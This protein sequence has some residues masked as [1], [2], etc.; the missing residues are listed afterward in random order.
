MTSPEAH[1]ATRP[2]RILPGALTAVALVFLVVSLL[3]PTWLYSPVNPAVP[4]PEMHL[5]FDDLKTATAES[6]SGVQRVYFAWLGWALVVLTVLSAVAATRIRARVTAMIGL[7]IA[8]VT[9]VI[10][11]FAVKG[12]LSWSAFFSNVPNIR[13]GGYLM[14]VG[15]LLVIIHAVLGLRSRA[16]R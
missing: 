3:G 1:T 8:V 9:L 10:T 7:V 6:A 15:L 14:I 4:L 12:S 16:V 5:S 11:V 2:N 13:L